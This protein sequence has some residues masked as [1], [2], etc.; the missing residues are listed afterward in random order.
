MALSRESQRSLLSEDLINAPPERS[1][2]PFN[3]RLTDSGHRYHAPSDSTS[4]CS[5]EVLRDVGLGISNSSGDTIP[6]QIPAYNRHST[7]S[8]VT[9]TP[10]S[11]S[12]S[13]TPHT[14][15]GSPETAL[16]GPVDSLGARCLCHRLF[17]SC[18]DA[19]GPSPR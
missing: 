8:T 11:Y 2:N 7:D 3:N 15:N 9:T 6:G 19:R 4:S 18:C 14:S 17:R 1:W 12:A 5:E 16:V 13:Q 10:N